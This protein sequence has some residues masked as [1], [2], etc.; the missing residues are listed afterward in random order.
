MNDETP[1]NEE[2]AAKER[3]RRLPEPIEAAGFALPERGVWPLQ[4]RLSPLGGA[5]RE[6]PARGGAGGGGIRAQGGGDRA[7]AGPPLTA[8]RADPEGPA[9]RRR[10]GCGHRRRRG[11][12]GAIGWRRRRVLRAD[13]DLGRGRGT[14]ATAGRHRPDAG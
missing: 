5:E 14:S 3:N 4:D 11:G 8:R 6:G 9:R 12:A 2:N 1:I 13:D 10:G 7:A